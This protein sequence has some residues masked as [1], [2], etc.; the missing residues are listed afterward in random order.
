MPKFSQKLM[1]A[2]SVFN[3][4]DTSTHAPH[5]GVSSSR[6][7]DRPR[8]SYSNERTII[9]AIY[10]RLSV[11]AASVEIRHIRLD[12]NGAYSEDIKSGIN[13]CLNVSANIDQAGRH[14]RQDIYQT[15]IELGEI[16][17]VPIET[18]LDPDTTGGYDIRNMRVGWIKGYLPKHVHVDAYNEETGAREPLTLDK[19][20]AAVVENPFYNVMN[21]PNSTLQRLARKLALLDVVDEASSSSKLD[22]IIQ[23]PYTVRS[24]MQIQKAE[25][26]LKEIEFQLKNSAHGIAYADATEKITQLNRP[27]ENTLLPQIEFLTTMLYDQLGLTPEIMNGTADEPTMTNYYNRTIGPLTAAVKE[28]FNRTFLTKT[29][30]SQGQTFETYWDPFIFMPLKDMA[31]VADILSRN[32]IVSPN[33]VR[34]RWLRMKP[35]KD[36]NAD[37][38]MNSNMPQPVEGEASTDTAANT[39]LDSIEQS[40][41]KAFADLGVEDDE[42]VQ[43]PE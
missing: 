34:T 26:R 7:Q 38:L 20:F 30:R 36:P 18:T 42:E 21:E 2:W 43:V 24:D 29:A 19:T 8:V 4:R 41:N 16:A 32:E 35:S 23:L 1:H 12:E 13:E 9:G 33:E 39:A 14:F 28:A 6:R 22:I 31:E 3:G 15:L 11:D 5:T 40:I 10:N 17:V 37:K 25:Q 27:A